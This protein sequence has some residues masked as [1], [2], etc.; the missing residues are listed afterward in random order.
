MS[1]YH[2]YFS[3]S[4]N[5]RPAHIP[6]ASYPDF[7][8]AAIRQSGHPRALVSYAYSRRKIELAGQHL[9]GGDL[10]VDSGAFSAYTKGRVIDLDAYADFCLEFA[11]A[12][13]SNLRSLRF[14]SLDVIGDQRA[15]ERNWMRL[16]ELGVNAMPVYT[17]GADLTALM[18][19]ARVSPYVAL[20]GLVPH[21]QRRELLRAHLTACEDA[22]RFTKGTRFHLLGIGGEDLPLR[23]P[24]VASADSSGWTTPMRFAVRRGPYRQPGDTEHQTIMRAL[25]SEAGKKR[26]MERKINAHRGIL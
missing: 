19:I 12:Y 10:I 25:V 20:G 17:Y 22:V 6:G 18:D 1:A 16:R 8:L 24:S 4:G 9:T 23:F 13:E 5:P 3:A 21:W 7:E 14:I 15:S 26:D 11:Q 2:Y